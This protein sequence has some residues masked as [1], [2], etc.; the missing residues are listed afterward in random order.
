MNFDVALLSETGPRVRNED[1]VGVWHLPGGRIGLAVADGLGGHAGGE[2]ASELAIKRLGDAIVADEDVNLEAIALAIHRDLKDQQARHP[3][4]SEMATTLS[5]V[6]VSR[7]N[8][9]GVHSGDSRVVV[10]RG[11]GIRKLTKDHREV[12]RLLMSNR[13]TPEQARNYPR[14]NILESAL[15]VKTEPQIDTI[16]F[17]IMSGDRIFLSSDGVHDKILLQELFEFSKNFK[18]A[19]DLVAA[20]KEEMKK[21]TPEDNY[22][23]ICC[24]VGK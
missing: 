9:T 17:K 14:R 5:A 3:E 2:I 8:L 21:R 7:E 1:R 4:W 24:F 12:Q 23:F 19:S 16:Q 18:S 13:I 10:S 22:S 6:I 20:I 11:G 15:G